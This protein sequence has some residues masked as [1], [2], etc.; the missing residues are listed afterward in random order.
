M[1]PAAN[2]DEISYRRRTYYNSVLIET[3][4]SKQV[5]QKIQENE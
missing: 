1:I 2:R 5:Y 3:I 4:F